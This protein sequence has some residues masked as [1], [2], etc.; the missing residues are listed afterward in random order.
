MAMGTRR[1]NAA[2]RRPL[3]ISVLLPGAAQR[4]LFRGE[5]RAPTQRRPYVATRVVHGEADVP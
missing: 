1:A 4:T 3:A 5:P 2:A